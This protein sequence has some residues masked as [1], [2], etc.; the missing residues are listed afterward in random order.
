M[1]P[2][3]TVHWLLTHIRRSGQSMSVPQKSHGKQRSAM[4]VQLM[5]QSA[6]LAQRVGWQ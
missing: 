6:L 5:L 1:Q 3:A 4:Q 2:P